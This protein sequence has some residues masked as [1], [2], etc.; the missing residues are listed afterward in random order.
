MPRTRSR[1]TRQ[2]PPTVIPSVV[3]REGA[4]I[5]L[6]PRVPNEMLPP[7]HRLKPLKGPAVASPRS[8]LL[9]RLTVPDC[10]RLSIAVTK[11]AGTIPVELSDAEPNSA[12]S[13]RARTNPGA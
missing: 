13:A 7:A 1:F 10:A 5:S 2:S 8:V 4:T 6:P 3:K 11:E 9:A 12:T